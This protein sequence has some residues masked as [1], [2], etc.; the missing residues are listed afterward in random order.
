MGEALLIKK[1]INS[2]GVPFA[3]I[4]VIYPSGSTCTCTNGIIIFTAPNTNGQV[5]FNIPETGE[6]T[7]SCTDGTETVSQSVSITAEGQFENVALSFQLHLFEAGIGLAEG[8]SVKTSGYLSRKVATDKIT[9]THTTNQNN[10]GGESG[11]AYFTPPIDCS[12]YSKLTVVA[13]QTEV[14]DIYSKTLVR[15]LTTSTADQTATAVAS[16]QLDLS[17]TTTVTIDLSSIDEVLYLNVGCF[18]ETSCEIT[19]ILFE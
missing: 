3:T 12:S 2:N 10:P 5:V 9:L 15:L 1:T 19:D 16:S 17:S 11:Q 13:K 8:Y 7:V 6:W 18:R 4:T 14:L